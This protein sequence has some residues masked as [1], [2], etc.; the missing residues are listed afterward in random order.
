MMHWGTVIGECDLCWAGL[1][2]GGCVICAR[3]RTS[4]G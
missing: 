3:T 2:R 4:S 1:E